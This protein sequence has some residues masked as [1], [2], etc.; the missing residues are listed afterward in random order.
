MATDYTAAE[1]AFLTFG[2]KVTKEQFS[3]IQRLLLP[4]WGTMRMTT[5]VF[6]TG[7][8][9]FA[10]GDHIVTGTPLFDALFILVWVAVLLLY[11][12]GLITFSRSRQWRLIKTT[13][14]DVTGTIGEGGLEWNTSISASALPWSKIVKVRRHPEMLLLFY[15]A[16]C[17]FYIPRNFFAS[18]MAWSEANLLITRHFPLNIVSNKS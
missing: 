16:K 15:H 3:L 7:A 17:A 6:V 9:V 14:H 13:H 10:L 11:V 8:L 18:E 12:W 1:A 4:W 2:G 5:I